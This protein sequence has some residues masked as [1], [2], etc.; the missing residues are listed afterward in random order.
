MT[1]KELVKKLASQFKD[2]KEKGIVSVTITQSILNKQTIEELESIE[3]SIEEVY[4]RY[5][6][7]GS[8]KEQK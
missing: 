7:K 1:K 8:D 3:K 5:D 4:K 6:T 2:L